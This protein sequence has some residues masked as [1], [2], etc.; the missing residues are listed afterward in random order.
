MRGV[1]PALAPLGHAPLL[2]SM[3][4]RVL[5]AAPCLSQS[6]L[7]AVLDSLAARQDQLA[8]AI[9]ELTITVQASRAVKAAP[10]SAGVSM[11]P[12]I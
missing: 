2:T 10:V 9:T 6:D 4:P 12:W 3:A 8:E 5:S 1:L 11:I 7:A